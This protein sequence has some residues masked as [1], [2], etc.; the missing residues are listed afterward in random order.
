MRIL[1]IHEHLSHHRQ[2]TAASLARTLG[3][4]D[5]T[6][7]RDIERMRDFGGAVVTWEPSTR[8]YIYEKPC[9]HLPLLSLDG[10]EALA[11]ILASRVFAAWRGTA[12]GQALHAALEKIAM[13]VGGAISLP[14]DEVGKLIFQSDDGGTAQAELRW[15]AALLSAIRRRREL[16]LI[17]RKPGEPKSERR[18]VH[19]L[20]LAW[21][22]HRWVLVAYDP[23]KAEPRKFVL[24]RIE[25]STETGKRFEPP[26]SFDVAS[27]L[28][29]SFGL[30]TGDKIEEVRVRFDAFAAPYIRERRWHPSQTLSELPGQGRVEVTLRLN[31]LIDVR[32]WIL[33]WGAH[34]EVLAPKELREAVR[35]EAAALLARHTCEEN[36][37]T[38]SQG[39]P[40]SRVS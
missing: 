18:W 13:T 26:A 34:V 30:F 27:Y 20:R 22:D 17:Y 37:G 31:N 39:Q 25:S 5:R 9:Q 12:L 36:E 23:K 28:E 16:V 2:A 21:L 15:F 19:P 4:S 6:I 40:V 8:T 3:V 11:L 1:R 38:Y 33:S 32:R 14:A 10:E 29:G 35:A 24:G 7:K